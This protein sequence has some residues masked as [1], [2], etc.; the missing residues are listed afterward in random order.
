MAQRTKDLQGMIGQVRGFDL[1]EFLS[2]WEPQGQALP[3]AIG[4]GIWVTEGDGPQGSEPSPALAA[5]AGP[6]MLHQIMAAEG[7][8]LK[9]KVLYVPDYMSREHRVLA[10]SHL[11]VQLSQ[12]LPGYQVELAL[13]EGPFEDD[14]GI[15]AHFERDALGRVPGKQQ[16]QAI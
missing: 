4:D 15:G 3:W 1:N 6:L 14:D 11:Y 8:A 7:V 2:D 10:T 9:L 13:A 16:M 12:A 5:P